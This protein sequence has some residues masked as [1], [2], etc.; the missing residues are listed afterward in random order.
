MEQKRWE[1]EYPKMPESFHLALKEVVEKNCGLEKSCIKESDVKKDMKQLDT[2]KE[3]QVEVQSEVL[4]TDIIDLLRKREEVPPIVLKKKN[5][6]KL[7]A[8]GMAAALT[9]GLAVVG[10]TAT[11]IFEKKKE[12]FSFEKYLGFDSR[13]GMEDLFQT[14]IKV[15]IPEEPGDLIDTWG[16]YDEEEW[17]E[18]VYNWKA[19]Q[20]ER[21]NNKPLMEIQEVFF[22]GMELAIHAKITEEGAQYELGTD[23]INI[24]Q[25]LI[26]LEYGERV[27]EENDMIFRTHIRGIE[28]EDDLEVV[29][30]LGVY[31]NGERYENQD[32]IFEVAQNAKITVLPEQEFIY[33]N[34]TI[35][36]SELVK[37]RTAIMGKV[38]VLMSDEQKEIY[39]EE[40][41]LMICISKFKNSD[42]TEWKHINSLETSAYNLLFEPQKQEEYFH[43]QMP[44][45]D[46]QSVMMDVLLAMKKSQYEEPMDMYHPDNIWVK[47]IEISLIEE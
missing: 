35:K 21:E 27:G 15:T 44:E 10:V 11:Q 23:T 22:D 39:E 17:E 1:N 4:Q 41:K 31:K 19:M 7:Y 20:I 38:E 29:I 45:P 37:S 43:K 2:K 9:L 25:H 42:G 32:Y 34:Y 5:R 40:N 30:P 16:T 6:K 8:L 28:Y 47:D 14:D 24:E 36:V 13:K 3:V 33:D 46:S 26:L 12:E 18:Y